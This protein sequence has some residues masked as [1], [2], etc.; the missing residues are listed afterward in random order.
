MIVDEM[1]VDEMAV[2]EMAGHHNIIYHTGCQFG[3]A[4]QPPIV[5]HMAYK[6]G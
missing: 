4:L 1:I 3:F 2:D 5:T 6:R